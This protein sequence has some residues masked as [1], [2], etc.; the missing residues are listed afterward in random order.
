MHDDE[1]PRKKKPE[2]VDLTKLSVEE[3]LEHILFLESEIVR[4]RGEI[5]RKTSAQRAADLFFKKT[6]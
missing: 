1:E 4:T 5:E 6:E 2:L 3:L